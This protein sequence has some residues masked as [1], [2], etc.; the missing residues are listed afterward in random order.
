MEKNEMLRR[1]EQLRTRRG[2][3]DEPV[4]YIIRVCEAIVAEYCGYKTRAEWEG[5]IN[6]K[7]SR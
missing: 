1:M 7:N 3:K 6:G 4:D 2:I 5:K